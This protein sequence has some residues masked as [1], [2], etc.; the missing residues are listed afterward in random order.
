MR[1]CNNLSRIVEFII[2]S[3]EG[4]IYRNLAGGSANPVST[5]I[6]QDGR[7]LPRTSLTPR[8]GKNRRLELLWSVGG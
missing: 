7:P 4:R 1:D 2:F 8:T 5:V 3:G 6:S